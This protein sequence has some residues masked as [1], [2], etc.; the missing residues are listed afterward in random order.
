MYKTLLERKDERGIYRVCC[1]SGS[2][3]PG[4]TP[5]IYADVARFDG[6]GYSLRMGSYCEAANRIFREYGEW[7]EYAQGI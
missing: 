6:T 5:G 3:A 7:P 2:E 1:L 4:E